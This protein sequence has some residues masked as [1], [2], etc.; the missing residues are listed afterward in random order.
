MVGVCINLEWDV[1]LTTIGVQQLTKNGHMQSKL[2]LDLSKHHTRSIH[3]W[4]NMDKFCIKYIGTEHT[5]H[6]KQIL[7]EIYKITTDWEEGAYGT[8]HG[9]ELQQQGSPPF[10]DK[11]YTKS[12]N[13]IQSPT[14]MET[15][16]S[17]ILPCTPKPWVDDSIHNAR[18]HYSTTC[19]KTNKIHSKGHRNIFIRCSS[20][21]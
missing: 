19:P 14:A 8:H 7:E 2:T 3:F 21:K 12:T 20:I 17:T 15:T 5:E 9:L 6:L 10:H 11:V 13:K 4:L 18:R 16:T 1:E